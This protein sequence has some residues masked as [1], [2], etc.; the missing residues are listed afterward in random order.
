MGYHTS[1]T[2]RYSTIKMKDTILYS[3]DIFNTLITRLTATPEGVFLA[4]QQRLKDRNLP[5]ELIN[6]F[7]TQRVLAEQLARKQSITEDITLDEIYA[8]IQKKFNLSQKQNQL[9]IDLEIETECIL[10]RGIIKN[11]NKV[12]KLLDEE[13]HVVFISDM[14]LSSNQIK[15]ILGHIEPRL[16][17]CKIYVSSEQKVC[18][19]T[20]N[21]FLSVA[22]KEK[23][24]LSQ[25]F[26]L[27]D[28][29]YSD[30]KIPQKLG[31]RA[32]RYIFPEK[33]KYEKNIFCETSLYTQFTLG[34]SICQRT[35]EDLS[36]IEIFGSSFAAPLLYGYVNYILNWAVN[37]HI[38]CLYFVARDGDILLKI[39]KEICKIKEIDIQLKYLHLSRQVCYL[40]AIN[41]INKESEILIKDFLPDLATFIKRFNIDIKLLNKTISEIKIN[42]IHQKLTKKQ[43]DKILALIKGTKIEEQLLNECNHVR[44][45]LQHYLIQQSFFNQADHVLIDIG[46]SGKSQDCLYNFLC[47][48]Q[49]DISL[50]YHYLGSS[51]D[52]K[53]RY[54]VETSEKNQK[55]FYLDQVMHLHEEIVFLEAITASDHGST[56][57]Y[58]EDETGIITPILSPYC[59]LSAWGQEAYH[60]QIIEFTYTFT[61]AICSF[62]LTLDRG[63]EITQMLLTESREPS[64]FILNTLGLHPYAM[65]HNDNDTD[66]LAKPL[67]FSAINQFFI[68]NIPVSYWIPGGVNKSTLIIKSYWYVVFHLKKIIRNLKST[69]KETAKQLKIK[70]RR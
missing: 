27:G 63:K 50:T 62:N 47:N 67:T 1:L 45:L 14:Y 57:N 33:L 12:L 32:E 41:H 38:H 52:Y 11:I 28:N 29:Y 5:P 64:T 46:W 68:H 55:F 10:A 65:G 58:Q 13:K 35:K 49:P 53:N 43:R 18:K 23:I 40:V 19:Y 7:Y 20:G 6:T 21:L 8:K 48:V 59:K 31:I 26:H 3:F 36:Q 17:T 61:K 60:K 24:K 56:Y 51:K 22:E 16:T 2:P 70:L 69:F 34:T 39:A 66:L 42:S 44:S 30:Y 25:I 15:E 4:M 54:S 9:L 37:N